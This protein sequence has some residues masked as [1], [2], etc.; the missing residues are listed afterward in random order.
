MW[1]K[2]IEMGVDIRCNSDVSEYGESEKEA[3][4]ICNGEKMTADV[5]VGADGVR[6]NARKMILGYE[7]KPK[8]S[9]YAIYRTWFKTKETDMAQDPLTS[10]LLQDHDTFNGWIGQDVHLLVTVLKN[11]EDCCWVITHKDEADIEESWSF[12]GAISDVVKIVESWDPRCAAIIKKAPSAVDWKLVYRDPLPK[13][14]SKEGRLAIIGDAAHPF[15]PTSIQGASQAMEDGITLAVV[16]KLAGKGDIP[17]AVRA[18][19]DIRYAR[20]R[21][22]QITGETNRDK[23]HQTSS[24]ESKKN[25]ETVKLSREAWLLGHD[26]HEHAKQAYPAVAEK[27]K[28]DGYKLPAVPS[29]FQ[30]AE[31]SQPAPLKV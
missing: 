8:S 20:V 2:A 9:G 7:D 14:V 25:P 11:A 23:W 3:W 18:F 1:N 15:L 29:S 26:A 5:V 30:D 28:K 22:A 12:P 19:E 31:I 6:S 16:L 4:V 24:E 17:T 27:L 10:W 13:W 21:R